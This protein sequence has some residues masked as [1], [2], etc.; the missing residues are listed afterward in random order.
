M[1]DLALDF[2]VFSSLLNFTRDMMGFAG[3]EVIDLFSFTIS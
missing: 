2:F 1:T 3:K